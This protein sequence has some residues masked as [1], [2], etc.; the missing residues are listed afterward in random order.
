MTCSQP[1]RVRNLVGGC[2]IVLGLYYL[3]FRYGPQELFGI[4]VAVHR[5]SYGGNAAGALA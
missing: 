2:L 4:F 3:S 5:Y 1:Y